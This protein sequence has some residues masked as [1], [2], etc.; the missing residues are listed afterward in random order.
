MKTGDSSC[1]TKLL[2]PRKL[3]PCTKYSKRCLSEELNCC[4]TVELL[5][6]LGVPQK[7][8]SSFQAQDIRTILALWTLTVV[9]YTR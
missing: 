2:I 4:V 7:R 3:L 5:F 6:F 8:S 1:E 9:N